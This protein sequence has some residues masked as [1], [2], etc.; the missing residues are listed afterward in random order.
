MELCQS[1]RLLHVIV[2]VRIS[3]RDPAAQQIHSAFTCWAG[4]SYVYSEV[5]EAIPA[6]GTRSIL[7]KLTVNRGAA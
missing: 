6:C 1:W 5:T 7:A 4:R 2:D 3:L